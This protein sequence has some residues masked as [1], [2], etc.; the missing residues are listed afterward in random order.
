MEFGSTGT[1]GLLKVGEYLSLRLDPTSND[2]DL[3]PVKTGVSEYHS[4]SRNERTKKGRQFVV[5]DATLEMIVGHCK[6]PKTPE[7]DCR[8]QQQEFAARVKPGQQRPGN[9]I[10]WLEAATKQARYDHWGRQNDRLQQQTTPSF[11]FVRGSSRLQG[12]EPHCIYHVVGYC[13]VPIN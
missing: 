7:L 13:F 1:L 6:P 10:D 8:S 5:K 9:S 12:S 3:S 4:E 2:E 11:C